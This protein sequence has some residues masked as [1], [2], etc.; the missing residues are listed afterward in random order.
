MSEIFYR[1]VTG[2][3]KAA[4]A[5]GRGLRHAWNVAA[6]NDRMVKNG[7]QPNYRMQAIPMVVGGIVGVFGGEIAALT[8]QDFMIW[9]QLIAAGIFIPPLVVSQAYSAFKCGE[10]SM[11]KRVAQEQRRLLEAPKPPKGLI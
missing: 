10:V 1:L 5:A 4:A 8:T 3:G 7:L 11:A 6:G 9:P 2:S